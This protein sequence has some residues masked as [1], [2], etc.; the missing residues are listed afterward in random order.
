MFA[1]ATALGSVYPN[2]LRYLIDEVIT[3]KQFEL[4]PRLA[5]VVVVVVSMKG[6]FQFLMAY[7]EGA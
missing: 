5:L 7:A 2:L 1:I 6:M 3:K 4:V